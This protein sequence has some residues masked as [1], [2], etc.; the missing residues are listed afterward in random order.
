MIKFRS[1]KRPEFLLI[2]KDLFQNDINFVLSISK[3]FRIVKPVL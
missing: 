1:S 2:S 3:L